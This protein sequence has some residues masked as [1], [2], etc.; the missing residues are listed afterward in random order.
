[1]RSSEDDCGHD[2]DLHQQASADRGGEL[3]PLE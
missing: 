3:E 1:M 2:G